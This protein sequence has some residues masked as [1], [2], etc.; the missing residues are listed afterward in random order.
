MSIRTEKV[1]SVVKKALSEPIRQVSNDVARGT[2]VTLTSVRMTK[3]LSLARV[4]L[5]VYGGKKSP[6]EVIALIDEHKTEIRKSI[7]GKVRLKTLPNLEFY[8][9]DTLD[10]MDN[11]QDLIDSTK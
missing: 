4:Y 3:D 2:L 6:L 9:D 5:S 7:A 8:M 1:A 11:I 10:Q